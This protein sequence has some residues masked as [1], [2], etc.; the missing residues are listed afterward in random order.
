VTET[1]S[2]DSVEVYFEVP[3]PA[4]SGKSEA[5]ILARQDFKSLQMTRSLKPG[6]KAEPEAPGTLSFMPFS[7][8]ASRPPT[9]YFDQAGAAWAMDAAPTSRFNPEWSNGSAYEVDRDRYISS[10][11]PIVGFR[12]G[13]EQGTDRFVL[14][15]L[16]RRTQVEDRDTRSG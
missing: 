3:N 14:H 5:G 8:G 13:P 16:K 9:L 1:F 10:E 4:T 6:L 7:H 11:W 2:P 15:P 12:T